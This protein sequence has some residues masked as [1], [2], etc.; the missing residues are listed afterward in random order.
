MT[1]DKRVGSVLPLIPPAC[2]AADLPIPE[3]VSKHVEASRIAI[4]RIL[5]GEDHRL[6]AVVG[7]C[8]IHD[9]KAA[10]EYAVKLK[11]FS[12]SIEDN[13][14]VIMRVYFEKPRSSIGWKG[15]IN[16]PDLD[17]SYRINKGLR[18]ARELLLN[19]NKIGLP[20]GCE[21]LDTISPQYIGG[22]VSW[23]A[24]G[25]R[26]V[27]SQIHRE[28]ASGLSCPIGFKNGTSGDVSVALD[29]VLAA[30]NPHNFL[31]VSHHGIASV[32]QSTGNLATHIILRGGRNGPNYMFSHL[33]AADSCS[34]IRLMVDCSHGNSGKDY[35]R[36]AGVLNDVANSICN[37][38]DSVIG[39]MIESNLIEGKQEL[40]PG[41]TNLSSLTYGMSVTDSCVGLN[42]TWKMLHV[43][44]KSA[45]IRV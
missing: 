4:S 34:D 30:R 38:Q 18:I 6:I 33:S 7:P 42:E 2:L 10:L 43:L 40:K 45:S 27:E 36:Q 24:I 16:D 28:L 31:G 39:V 12:M 3:S 32:I 44:S 14:L 19:I 21:F 35:R 26:T 25:A 29:A 1:V 11:E 15:L 23:G 9:P 17:G 13:I 41:K 20:V 22:L 37:G 8:S 5:S